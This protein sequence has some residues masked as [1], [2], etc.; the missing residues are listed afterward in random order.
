M[1]TGV[2]GHR[3]AAFV[4]TCLAAAVAAC[5]RSDAGTP[6]ASLTR[7]L[8]AAGGNRAPAAEAPDSDALAG[9]VRT[10]GELTR[11]QALAV[12]RAQRTA[13]RP[14]TDSWH[15]RHPYA[16][17]YVVGRTPLYQHL[18]QT[19]AAD[20][21][22]QIVNAA[23]GAGF[24]TLALTPSGAAA[25]RAQG[26]TPHVGTMQETNL[27]HDTIWVGAVA[28]PRVVAVTEIQRNADLR[29]VTYRVARVLTP[30]G[31][32][33]K[34]FVPAFDREVQSEGSA[35]F[36]RTDVGWRLRMNEL[37]AWVPVTAEAS[38]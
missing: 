18:I 2:P 14:I 1:P 15:T 4:A 27:P 19:R 37:G 35:L 34:P 3:F 28:R 6:N 7:D 24:C 13:N 38:R 26:W 17:A 5:S 21:S 20:S 36:V 33:L 22:T 10:S 29:G 11:D 9:V 31:E 30:L 32:S 12:L 8:A 16:C 23:H 25:I